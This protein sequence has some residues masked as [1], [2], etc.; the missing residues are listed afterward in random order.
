MYLYDFV[1]IIIETRKYG[2]CMC[3][4]VISEALIYY[5]D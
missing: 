3:N 4:I 5:I 2:N 1:S